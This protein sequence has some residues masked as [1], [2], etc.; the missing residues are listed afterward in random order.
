MMLR[1][2]ML[3]IFA[4][5]VTGL[6][7]LMLAVCFAGP[8]AASLI[9]L[10]LDVSGWTF[11]TFVFCAVLA[12]P[13]LWMVVFLV[14]KGAYYLGVGLAVGGRY[15]L[16][17]R[18]MNPELGLSPMHIAAAAVFAI[19][20]LASSAFVL[21]SVGNFA[22]LAAHPKLGYLFLLPALSIAAMWIS[23]TE[24]DHRQLAKQ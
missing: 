23:M 15:V 2:V 4:M 5:G 10:S 13:V 3:R 16:T 18:F 12:V 22:H 19:L 20:A 14:G 21:D 6:V 11:M 9:G 1:S 8:W 17:R 7:A 24:F